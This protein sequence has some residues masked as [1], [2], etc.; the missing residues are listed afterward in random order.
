[1]L[2]DLPVGEPDPLRRLA[3]IHA[4]T[5][6]AKGRLYAGA[7]DITEVVHLPIPLARVGMRW[8]RRFGG[9][10]VN[11]FVT[12]VPG[13]TAPLW[14]AGAR[15]LEAVPVA[16]LVQN[17]GLGVAALS[18]AGELAVSVH[19]DGSVTDLELLADGMAADFAAFRAA[20]R[21]RSRP[22]TRVMIRRPAHPGR[23]LR[24]ATS[25]SQ[26]RLGFGVRAKVSRSTETR[27]KVAR[28]RSTTRSCPAGSSAR[29]RGRRRRR[30][31][32]RP[33]RA[34]RR[35]VKAIRSASSAVAMPFSVTSSGMPGSTSA[36]SADRGAERLGP[37]LHAVRQGLLAPAPAAI[38]PVGAEP[39]AGVDLQADEVVAG[40]GLEELVLERG[41]VRRASAPRRRPRRCTPGRP[42]SCRPA[43]TRRRGAPPGCGRAGRAARRQTAW[44]GRGRPL[45]SSPRAAMPPSTGWAAI[46]FGSLRVATYAASRQRRQRRARRTGRTGR[47]PSGRSSQP[48]CMEPARHREVARA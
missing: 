43:G 4:A 21:P 9:T 42:A 14:L 25:P 40:G 23:P 6:R 38:E 20:A 3:A 24:R 22:G 31:S 34:A 47:R 36:A 18:Y 29:S 35:S 1:M 10:R 27:P 5:A 16:P 30:R 13:P 45:I 46:R 15:M 48:S 33:G 19:A 28:S 44:S 26:A 12:D 17:V 32:P 41:A 7:G 11:L 39:R 8:M 2:V 37:A